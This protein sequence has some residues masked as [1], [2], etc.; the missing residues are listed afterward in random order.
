MGISTL[1]A[2]VYLKVEYKAPTDVRPDRH[3]HLS[4]K[5]KGGVF[6]AFG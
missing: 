6:M 3:T 4:G 5:Q 1:S 2:W